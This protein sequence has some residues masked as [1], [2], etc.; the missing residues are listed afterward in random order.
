[1]FLLTRLRRLSDKNKNRVV[2]LFS[3]SV[4]TLIIVAGIVY[5]SFD[6]PLKSSDKQN[7]QNFLSV[8]DDAVMSTASS[9]EYMQ[10]RLLEIKS[11]YK[12]FFK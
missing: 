10:S 3:I 9:L 4:T 1:M 5:K 12:E 6:T 8:A 2:L 11:I 7:T